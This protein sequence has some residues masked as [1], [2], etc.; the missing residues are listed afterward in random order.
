MA[1]KR[2]SAPSDA[3]KLIA[4]QSR[5]LK[6]PRIAQNYAR[7]AEQGRAAGW[8][9]EDY[10]AAVLAVESNARAESG[11]RLRIRAAA[12]PA[13]KT[14]ADFDFTAQ[15]AVDRAHIARLEAGGWLSEA[16]NIVLLGPPGT[17]KTHL[18]TALAVAA[19]HTGYRVGFASATAWI[20][21]LAEAHRLGRLD[22][23]LKKI[24]RIGLIVI[25]EVGYI[26]FDA[27]A[28][29]LFFQLVS[30]RY[31]KSS[32]I[33][34]SNLSFSRWGEVFG[35]ATI[36]SAMIDRIVHHAD[37]IALKGTSYRIKHTAIESLPS[38]EADRE[39]NS[40]P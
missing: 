30:S 6:A 19:A 32:I 25:D 21:R 39:A 9:L 20:T 3:D 37:V 7:I 11:A 40:N 34:T 4:H 33:L 35:E 1:T 17:G 5:L 13:I 10:L 29:N 14:I 36:A 22:A 31:E 27:E 26:P 15:P 24:S 16:R 28:A 38:V 12:F 2:P 8:A 23:E 18:A